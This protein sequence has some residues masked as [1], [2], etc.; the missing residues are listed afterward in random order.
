MSVPPTTSANEP[1]STAP[2]HH[3]A[4]DAPPTGRRMAVLTL[5]ALGVVYGDIGTSP[6]YALKECFKPEYGVLLGPD[7]QPLPLEQM[8]Q[9]VHGLLSTIVWTLILVVALKYI[10]YIMRADNR[11]QGGILAMLALLLQQPLS[12]TKGRRRRWLFTCLALIGAALLYGDGIITPPISIL[13]ALE[14][15][16][17]RN[18]GLG[19]AIVPLT[20]GILFLLFFFQRLGTSKVGYLFGPIMLLWFGTMAILGVREIFHH[21]EILA[22]VD[23]RYAF[24]FFSTHGELGF[25]VL[26]AIVL[27]VTGAEALY[28][29]M[30]HFGRRPIQFAWFALVFPSLLLNYFGQG[31]LLLAAPEKALIEEFNPFFELAPPFLVLPLVGLAMA[32][33]II[34]SQALIS[35]AFSLTQQCVQLGYSPRMTIV[36]TSAREA[37]QIYI[38]EVN[39]W[40]CIGCMLVVFIFGSVSRLSAAYGIAVTGTMAITSLLFFLVARQRWG[41]SLLHAGLLTALFLAIDLALFGAN[42]H[43]VHE[44]GWLP[45]VV[46]LGL[47]T[48]MTS[49]KRGRDMLRSQLRAKLPLEEFLKDLE[50]HKR[51]RVTGTAVFMTSEHT[52]VPVVLLHHLKH[53]KV[54][55]EQ[56]ILLSIASREVPQVDL[57]ERL[58]VETLTQGFHRV[59]AN[60][61]YM[62]KP[63]V[64]EIMQL[65]GARGIRTKPLDT[66]YFLGRERLIPV[67]VAQPGQEGKMTL[68]RKYVFA[69]LTRNAIPATQYFGIPPNRVVELGTQIEF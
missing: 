28:A 53:N 48:L 69:W 7:K 30:G 63:A 13:G 64:A 65:L 37:G 32:A 50:R 14:G 60:Y 3:A 8:T 24:H 46:A 33:A 1:G 21:P 38:P 25:L 9:T 54:L 40:L 56:V 35:G 27:A 43:K 12:G 45:L 18:P 66:T 39:S 59:R 47:F 42:I 52:G 22:A 10:V 31:A 29:D 67:A 15:I 58:E 44:G 51:I 57:D 4:H 23:P 49:W 2:G 16:K 5:T 68:W 19:P 17:V 41:W 61:G 55:H 11:G 34:A 36:H 26:G 20:L 62:E 6:L